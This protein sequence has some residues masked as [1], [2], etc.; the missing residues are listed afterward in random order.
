MVPLWL[1]VQELL[2]DIPAV[3]LPDDHDVYHGNVWG[4]GGK[5]AKGSGQTGQDS[6]GY[7]MPARFVKAV[8]RTQTSNMPAPY[9]PNTVEQDIGVYYTSLLFAIVEDRKWK[10]A[11]KVVLLV[12]LTTRPRTEMWQ[13]RD[14]SVKGSS[15]FLTLGPQIGAA[16][17]G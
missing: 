6:G 16:V 1:G 11:P 10:S 13:E 14:S 5:R 15:S 4:A 2:K 17:H 3:A 12:R 7:V 8:E 9:D